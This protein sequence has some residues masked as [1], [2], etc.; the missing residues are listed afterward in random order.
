MLKFQE[1]QM[2]DSLVLHVS[3]RTGEHPCPKSHTLNRM[4]RA[5]L[6]LT[7]PASSAWK[8]LLGGWCRFNALQYVYYDYANCCRNKTSNEV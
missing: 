8:R 3:S 6:T 2:N 5:T 7:V 4:S 1:R